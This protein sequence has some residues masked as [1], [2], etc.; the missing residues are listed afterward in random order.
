MYTYTKKNEKFKTRTKM[1]LS[2][3]MFTL[4]RLL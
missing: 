2:A 4:A 1:Q 3:S